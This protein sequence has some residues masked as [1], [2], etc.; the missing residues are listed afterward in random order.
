MAYIDLVLKIRVN[1]RQTGYST[2]SKP[3]RSDYTQMDDLEQD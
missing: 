2:V 1:L 3:R